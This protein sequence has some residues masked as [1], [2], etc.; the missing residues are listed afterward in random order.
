[1]AEADLHCDKVVEAAQ[2][3]AKDKS[4]FYFDSQRETIWSSEH[5]ILIYI[6]IYVHIV[7][8]TVFLV[9]HGKSCCVHLCCTT[10]DEILP[11]P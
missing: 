7:C 9:S 4:C 5:V 8:A 3:F 11:F 1:M 2:R 10:L 6:Y